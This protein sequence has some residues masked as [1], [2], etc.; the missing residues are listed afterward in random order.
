MIRKWCRICKAKTLHNVFK[1]GV[2]EQCRYCKF[3]GLVN[4]KEH[5][6]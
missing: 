2:C 4:P 1:G 5:T 3:R 6:K